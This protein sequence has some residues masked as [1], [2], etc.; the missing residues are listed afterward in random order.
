[1]SEEIMDSPE[2]NSACNEGGVATS[3]DSAAAR[4]S[5]SSP[6]S[7]KEGRENE[8]DAKE[9]EVEVRESQVGEPVNRNERRH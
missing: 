5:S 3:K 8:Q 2:A 7:D 4:L 6:A 9:A 1:M